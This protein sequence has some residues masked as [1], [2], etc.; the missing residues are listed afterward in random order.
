M[1]RDIAAQHLNDLGLLGI[2]GTFSS[3]QA[4]ASTRPKSTL[5]PGAFAPGS[6][7]TSG[8][9]VNGAPNGTQRTQVDG[10]DRTNGINSV[11][12]GNRNQRGRHAGNRPPD[13]KL[14]PGIR[15]VGGGLFNITM[16]S[17]T[18]Q[19]HGGAYDYLANED[20]DE[21]TPFVNT[22]QGIRRN[23][24]GFNVGGPV[25]I[26]K[27]YNG[28]NRTFFFYNREEYKE[29]APVSDISITVPTAAYRGGNF[30]GAITGGSLGNDPL[31]NPIFA[32]AIYDPKTERTVNGQVVRL[33]FPGNIIPASR[34]DPV[35]LAIQNLIP[36]PTNG[37]A[38]L[39][40]LV[41]IPS[42]RLTSNESVKID[43]QLSGNDQTQRP[44]FDQL[45]QL[46]IFAESGWI[47]GLPDAITSDSRH[48]Q[49]IPE[50]PSE[51][52]LDTKS[53]A[54]SAPGCGNP[55]ISAATIIRPP[56]ISM[57]SDRADRPFQPRQAVPDDRR[58]VRFGCGLE[59]FAVP[60]DGRNDEHG[61]RR[62]RHKRTVDHG[63]DDADLSG[64]A[65]V[66]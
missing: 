41:N 15:S 56:R 8:V 66:G 55:A 64:V 24:Y 60:R 28:R 27:L 51:F 3:S 7:F 23:D 36:M 14:L 44:V 46:P 16:K 11:Q 48:L 53:H 22:L 13:Q 10:M 49:Q 65:D 52:R 21:A 31:G 37:N 62:W 29:N 20:F 26:P 12:A 58:I 5:V 63:S 19:Y 6:G 17:G 2:G 40:D 50:L 30:A 45:Q 18:N 25:W 33:Q 1:S 34:M 35:A 43:H 39:N 42:D 32:G 47:E 9:R 57:T 54:A 61:T 4:C 59:H 38:A